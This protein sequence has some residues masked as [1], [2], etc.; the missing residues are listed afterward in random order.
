MS[1]F[2]CPECLQPK[3]QTDVKVI[4]TVWVDSTADI[5]SRISV[6]TNCHDDLISEIDRVI[7]LYA[8]QLAGEPTPYRLT[9][10]DM[11]PYLKIMEADLA[12]YLPPATISELTNRLRIH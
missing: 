7:N 12:D 10:A 3:S 11:L 6:C 5:R 9:N 4:H 2:V 1:E 8:K